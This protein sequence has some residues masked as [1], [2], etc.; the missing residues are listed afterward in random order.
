MSVGEQLVSGTVS[1]LSVS[2]PTQVPDTHSLS[3]V[4]ELHGA[5]PWGC[6]ALFFPLQVTW[7]NNMAIVRNDRGCI[8]NIFSGM[9]GTTKALLVCMV[10]F[11]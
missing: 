3:R 10:W 11:I 8:A 9:S 1:A 4:Q 2:L 7:R 5:Q 6:L